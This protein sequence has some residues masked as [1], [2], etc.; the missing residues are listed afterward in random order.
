MTTNAGTA[1][2]DANGRSRRRHHGAGGNGGNIASRV[3]EDGNDNNPHTADKM[4]LRGGRYESLPYA[5]QTATE[6]FESIGMGYES[7]RQVV[8]EGPQHPTLKNMRPKEQREILER[9]KRGIIHKIMNEASVPSMFGPVGTLLILNDKTSVDA[10]LDLLTVDDNGSSSAGND[11][12]HD[13]SGMPES[14]G[15]KEQHGQHSVPSKSSGDTDSI[16]RRNIHRILNSGLFIAIMATGNIS[17]ISKVRDI[18]EEYGLGFSDPKKDAQGEV[19]MI[20]AKCSLPQPT[21][22][23]VKDYVG[24]DYA[25]LLPVVRSLST[26]PLSEQSSMTFDDLLMMIPNPPGEIQP[27]GVFA[28]RTTGEP[29]REG[30]DELAVRGDRDGAMQLLV[31]VINGGKMPIIYSTWFTR[32]VSNVCIMLALMQDGYSQLEA[33][34]A[35]KTGGPGYTKGKPDPFNGLGGWSEN[36]LVSLA[37]HGYGTN[38]GKTMPADRDDLLWLA[39]ELAADNSALRGSMNG[40]AVTGY[41]LE[42]GRRDDGSTIVVGMVMKTA[43]VFS[44]VHRNAISV[45]D[46]GDIIGDNDGDKYGISDAMA[47]EI[48]SMISASGASTLGGAR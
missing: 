41:K 36:H 26:M 9:D 44:G 40:H 24:D 20:L 8:V 28:N 23:E 16:T 32:N 35:V 21:M 17:S 29:G 6:W 37:T 3:N 19:N 11:K 7:I 42:D 48:D 38:A 27:W 33:A 12:N 1:R 22:R 34:H 45:G 13:S 30:L 18:I 31:R 46:N 10:F 43:L 5:T 14:S 39:N 25:I 4:P 15:R 47:A 2:N